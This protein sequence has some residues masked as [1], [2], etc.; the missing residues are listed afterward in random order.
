MAT[1]PGFPAYDPAEF[2]RQL[3]AYTQAAQAMFAEAMKAPT[4]GAGRGLDPLNVAPAMHEAASQLSMSPARLLQANL[5]LWQQHMQ[6]WQQ[7]AASMAAR[8]QGSGQPA[9]PALPPVAEPEPG[10]RRFRHPDWQENAL[11][12]Y[13]KQSYLITSRWLVDTM[14]GLEG[15]DA[16]TAKKVN[17]YTRQFADA[18]AP[19]NFVW[20]NPEVLRATW[21]SQGRNLAQGIENFKRDMERGKGELRITMSDPDAFELGVNLA[22]TPGKVVFQNDLLQLIQFEPVTEQVHRTPILMIPAWINK[23]YILDLNEKKSFIRWALGQGYTVFAVSWVNP[24]ETLAQKTFDDYLVEGVI[25]ALDAVEAA[26]GEHEVSAVGYCIGGTMLAVALGYLA[27]IGDQRIKAATMLTAQVD[28]SE[29]GDLSV[30]IDEKQLDNLD[31]MMGDKGYLE[32]QAMFTTFNMLRANDLIWSFFVNNYLLGKEAQPFDLLHWNAD[33]TRMPRKMHLFYLRQMYLHNNLVKPGVVEL[34][35][36]P[37]DLTKV[38]VPVYLEACREDHIAPFRS[39]FKAR[40]NFSGPVRF[41]LAGS[42]HIAGV[43]NPP[44]AKKYQYWRNDDEPWE[45]DAWLRGAAE[46]PGSW[47]P[48]WQDWLAAHSGEMVPARKPGDGKLAVIEAAPGS[49]VKVRSA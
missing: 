46:H 48:D 41:L 8:A 37:I 28:F 31:Q 23:Y 39:V 12:D 16:Q 45:I 33:A 5:Q 32:G 9:A 25:A 27:G 20:T 21:E 30:F 17:F 24:D 13:I 7:M 6:L 49:F 15:L 43:I 22:T 44:D 4:T 14:S 18:F 40:H 3:A 35:G 2:S 10:D 34:A 38:T 42:G 26:T 36:V 1:E 47:W 19:S 11:F 29:P